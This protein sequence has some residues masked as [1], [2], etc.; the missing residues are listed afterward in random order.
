MRRPAIAIVAAL[1]ALLPGPLAA[2]DEALDAGVDWLVANQDSLG[3]WGSV[4]PTQLR[5]ATAVLATLGTLDADSTAMARGIDAV[6]GVRPNSS[7]YL[8]RM[9]VA[10]SVFRGGHMPEVTI[11]NLISRQNADGGWG[12]ILGYGSN[13]LDTA[14]ALRALRA[15]PDTS[16]AVL[17]AGVAYTTSQQNADGGWAIVGGDSSC[18]FVTAHVVIGLA[19]LADDLD[20]AT[21]AQRG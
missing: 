21:Q 15:A 13:N 5:D 4:G 14:L 11:N 19:A 8:A 12:Y 3:W 10:A 18:V 9:A 16:A 17:E 6:N 1:L 2:Q 7:D 20:V